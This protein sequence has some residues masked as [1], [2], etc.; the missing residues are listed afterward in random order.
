MAQ[1]LAFIFAFDFI[2]AV[3]PGVMIISFM[4]YLARIERKTERIHI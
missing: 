4:F 3:L 2:T 1:T